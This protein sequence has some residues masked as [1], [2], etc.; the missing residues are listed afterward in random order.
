MTQKT[1]S[2][3]LNTAL[4]FV[5]TVMMLFPL[6]WIFVSSVMPTSAVMSLQPPLIPKWQEI[7]FAAYA[8]I[9][10]KSPLLTWLKNSIVITIFS[11]ALSVVISTLAGY[12]LSR[13]DSFGQKLMGFFLIV[14]KMLPGTLI[15]IPMFI[16]FSAVK[17]INNPIAVIMANIT[18]IIPFATWMM[19]GFFDDIPQELEEAATVDGCSTFKALLLVIIPLAMPGLA[20]IAIYSSIFSWG[21][22]LFARTLMLNP[23][24]WTMTIGTASFLGEYTINWNGLMAASVVSMI[25]MVII[26][27]LFESFL[28]K[29]LT[30]GSLKG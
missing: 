6:Y 3:I 19:K 30:T 17:L 10:A 14:N 7:S 15:I 22:F 25:P 4:V 23:D 8:D 9:F 12:S 1:K 2:K 18:A 28:V 21:E 29:G 16:M 20:A 27:F 13:Y 5:I 24:H 26:F 11:T